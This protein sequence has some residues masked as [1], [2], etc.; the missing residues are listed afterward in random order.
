MIDSIML[1][2]KYPFHLTLQSKRRVETREPQKLML[3]NKIKS[4]LQKS[5]KVD[6]SACSLLPGLELAMAEMISVARSF[7]CALKIDHQQS[8]RNSHGGFTPSR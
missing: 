8:R 7:N 3:I 4:V 5:R 1:W 2:G 6:M